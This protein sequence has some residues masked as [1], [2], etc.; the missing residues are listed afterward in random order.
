MDLWPASF[1]TQAT[2]PLP[3]RRYVGGQLQVGGSRGRW[4]GEEHIVV[5]VE[6]DVEAARRELSLFSL[7]AAAKPYTQKLPTL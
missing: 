3:S 2:H 4:E 1:F 7:N 6:E 5:L